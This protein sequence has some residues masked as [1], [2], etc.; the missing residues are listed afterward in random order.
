MKKPGPPG[1]RHIQTDC[2]TFRKGIRG[3]RFGSP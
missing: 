2:Y 1:E 3:E